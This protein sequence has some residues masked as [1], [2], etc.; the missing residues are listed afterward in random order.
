MASKESI[1]VSEHQD[2]LGKY[3]GKWIA[4]LKGKLLAVGDSVEAVM[5]NIKKKN[6]KELPLVIMVPKKDEEMYVL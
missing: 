2:E 5:K 3:E 4:V 1:W 6:I